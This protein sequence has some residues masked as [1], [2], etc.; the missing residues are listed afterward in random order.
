M[1]AWGQARKKE[2]LGCAEFSELGLA[3]NFSTSDFKRLFFFL[4][5]NPCLLPFPASWGLVVDLAGLQGRFMGLILKNYGGTL[6]LELVFGATSASPPR[7]RLQGA[8]SASPFFVF[9][10]K[11]WRSKRR[12]FSRAEDPEGS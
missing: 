5:E 1:D 4:H 7:S 11:N 6:F 12:D 8:T 9:C 10:G 3:P 2:S